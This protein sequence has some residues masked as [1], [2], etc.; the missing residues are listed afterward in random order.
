[1]SRGDQLLR[2]WKL[3]RMLQT[4]GEGMPLADLAAELQVVDRTVQ[5]DL[6]LLQ[7]LGFPISF[8][9]DDFGKRFWRMPHDYFK[10]GPLLL[11]LTE[12]ISLHLSRHFFQPL[13][14]TLFAQGLNGALEKVRAVLPSGALE[15]FAGLEEAI[16]VRAFG[17]V[18]YS[19]KSGIL[20]TLLD[21]A[22]SCQTVTIEYRALW[23][24]MEYTTEFDPYGIVIF[25]D[26][27]FV[28]GLSHRAR[29]T[30]VFKVARIDAVHATS[31]TFERPEDF[32]LETTFR[33]SFG[34]MR[35]DGPLIEIAVRFTGA[36]AALVEEK[37]WHQS[38]RL[39]W[40]TESE[41]LFEAQPDTP[42]ALIATFRL[43][44]LVEFKRWVLSFGGSAEVLRPDT[45]RAEIRD[46]LLAAAGQ[47]HA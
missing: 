41:M 32:S 40:L 2:Q 45:L 28:I 20:D 13:T 31:K 23:R 37:E 43:S 39:Q 26:D 29:E 38:Q 27:L 10:T 42:A 9:A 36:L 30:R 11:S 15:Y 46:E 16:H 44:N 22:R 24:R 8:D 21:A 5:R 18:N 3:L 12:A 35:S 1:M 6:E 47:Y 25:E 17:T 34:I 14:G 19:Q 33:N 7:E 4:R